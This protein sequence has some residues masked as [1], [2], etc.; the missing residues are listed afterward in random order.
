MRYR[1][2][3]HSLSLGVYLDKSL[4]LKDSY[5]IFARVRA[6]TVPDYSLRSF[7]T[8]RPLDKAGLGRQPQLGGAAVSV[9]FPLGTFS[10]E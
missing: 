3:T 4:I 7:S 2:A 10:G 8:E 6:S 5:L 9:C 1:A